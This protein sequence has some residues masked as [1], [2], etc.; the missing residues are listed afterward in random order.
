MM[1]L[2]S[3][4]KYDCV[5]VSR[6]DSHPTFGLLRLHQGLFLWELCR[7]QRGPTHEP[8]RGLRSLVA[9]GTPAA[10]EEHP[11]AP[12]RSHAVP[13]VVVSSAVAG[14]R[15]RKAVG[16]GEVSVVRGVWEEGGVSTRNGQE[17]QQRVSVSRG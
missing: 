4:G 13:A 12:L 15:G 7:G 5:L 2:C 17:G 11:L 10:A 6:T 8:L 14:V 1:L 9:P 3:V 16:V